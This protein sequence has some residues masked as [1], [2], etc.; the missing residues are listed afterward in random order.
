M[1][2]SNCNR[3]ARCCYLRVK[4]SLLEYLMIRLRGYK[5]FMEKN[6]QNQRCIIQDTNNKCFFLEGNNCRIYSIRPKMCRE[7]PG[8]DP[9]SRNP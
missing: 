1:L 8:L 6:A 2:P 9:C 5:N 4:I 3:C 7:Y